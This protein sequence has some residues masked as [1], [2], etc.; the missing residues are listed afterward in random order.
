[1]REARDR[2]P[3]WVFD[4]CAHEW[5]DTSVAG[6]LDPLAVTLAALDASVS[7]AVVTLS[8]DVLVSRKTHE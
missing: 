2:G 6:P 8:L 7:A 3:G 5:V 1:V 4:V